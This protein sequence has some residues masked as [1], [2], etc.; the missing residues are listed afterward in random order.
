MHSSV[1]MPDGSIV[2][3]GGWDNGGNQLGNKHGSASHGKMELEIHKYSFFLNC[4]DC[5]DFHT[6]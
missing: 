6:L 4:A 2:L 5:D 3:M 1:V